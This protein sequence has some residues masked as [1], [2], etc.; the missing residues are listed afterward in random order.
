VAAAAAAAAV[1][2][3]DSA[4]AAECERAADFR[5]QW[6]RA[7]LRGPVPVPAF[8]PVPEAVPGQTRAA[9]SRGLEGGRLAAFVLGVVVAAS[10]PVAFVLAL[11]AEELARAA[12]AISAAAYLRA[13]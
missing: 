9:E 11:V 4:E 8:G 13:I 3:V 5:R 2:A 10:P 12:W 6:V 1:P 7:R